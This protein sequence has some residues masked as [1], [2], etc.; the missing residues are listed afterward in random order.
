MSEADYSPQAYEI[1]KAVLKSYLSP[2]GAVGDTESNQAQMDISNIITGVAISQ[3][4]D[5]VSFLVNVSVIDRANLLETVPLRAEETLDLTILTNDTG[6]KIEMKL[7]VYEISDVTFGSGMNGTNYTMKCV[8][9]TTYDATTRNITAPWQGK[10]ADGVQFFFNG[11]FGKVRDSETEGLPYNAKRFNIIKEPLGHL[12]VQDTDGIVEFIV[13]NIRPQ[14]AMKFMATRSYNPNTPS[15]T[16]RFF[17]RTDGYFFVTDEYFFKQNKEE[18]INLFY[19]IETPQVQ[20]PEL[21]TKRVD[22]L[23]IISTGRNVPDHL[24]SG[25]YKSNVKEIDLVRGTVNTIHYDYTKD[26]KFVDADGVQVKPKNSPHS[27]DFIADTFTDENAKDMVLFKDY[28]GLGDIPGSLRGEAHYATIAQNRIAYY[29]HIHDVQLSIEITGRSDIRP[30]KVV[31]LNI[32]SASLESGGDVSPQ[33]NGR[34]LVSDTVHSYDK[35]STTT[36]AKLIKLNW[37]GVTLENKN[38][39]VEGPR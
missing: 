7:R 32:Q 29:H 33:L 21:D 8:S 38:E 30:G 3:S 1:E 22:K 11:Y 28:A 31:D 13:P 18:Y 9:Q 35:G 19:G 26:A 10:I 5:A 16:F 4:I 36:N 2:D 34:Y 25:A 15:Q 17:E 37:S 39:N 12:T 6:E 20:N 27:K 14:S 23:K 24:Y